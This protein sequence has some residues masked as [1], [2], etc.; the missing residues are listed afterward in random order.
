MV[1]LLSSRSGK[2]IST[3]LLIHVPVSANSLSGNPP[4]LPPPF[5]SR[6]GDSSTVSITGRHVLL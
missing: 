4:P 6:S 3:A 2:K 5:P 1:S